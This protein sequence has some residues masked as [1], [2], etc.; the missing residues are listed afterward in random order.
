[1]PSGTA[2]RRRNFAP[3]RTG[4]AALL[5]LSLRAKQAKAS[6]W[7]VQLDSWIWE[8]REAI[9]WGIRAFMLAAGASALWIIQRDVRAAW[10]RIV[11]LWRSRN[12]HDA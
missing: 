1:M 12:D 2:Q 11:E 8:H 10:P 9:T 5:S 4:S 3:A 6:I 7:E